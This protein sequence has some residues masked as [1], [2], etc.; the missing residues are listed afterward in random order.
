MNRIE[1]ELFERVESMGKSAFFERGISLMEDLEEH[2]GSF[3]LF[4]LM[5]LCVVTLRNLI[6]S[7]TSS[8]YIEQFG[9]YTLHYPLAFV[10][11]FL[12]LSILL[13]L[14]SGEPISRVSKLMFFLWFLIL[15]PP[16]VDLIRI[17][18][19][20]GTREV[21]GW[22]NFE[23]DGFW[24]TYINL[25]NPSVELEGATTGIRIQS[26]LSCILATVY[27]VIKSK[28]FVR[29]VITPIVISFFS[30]CFFSLPAL[31]VAVS[32]MITPE[33]V[34][35][36][37]MVLYEGNLIWNFSQQAA[38]GMAIYQLILAVILF[39][40]WLHFNDPEKLKLLL[41][42]ID[43]RDMIRMISFAALGFIIGWGMYLRE[44]D[45]SSLIGNHRDL[46]GIFAVS[47]T[48]VSVAFFRSAL[49]GRSTRKH[50]Y[51]PRDI[52]IVSL[53]F[54]LAFAAAASYPVLM[55]I[56]VLLILET[57]SYVSPFNVAAI[58]VVKQLVL[59]TNT[60]V[61]CLIGFT[62]FTGNLA[63]TLFPTIITITVLVVI[64]LA[65]LGRQP[66]D[67]TMSLTKRFLWFGPFTL[68]IIAAG[69]LIPGAKA[70]VG[71]SAIA[72]VFFVNAIILKS[73]QNGFGVTSL[74]AFVFGVHCLW[75]TLPSL[76]GKVRHFPAEL[77]HSIYATFLEHD[78]HA[79][80]AALEFQKAYD[81][82]SE[83]PW[84]AFQLG[85]YAL[86][87][88][89]REQALTYY[90][91]ALEL[92]PY[93]SK[94]L[95]NAAILLTG[96]DR[97]EESLL[98]WKRLLTEGR[99]NEPYLA[100]VTTFFIDQGRADESLEMLLT[101]EN[102]IGIDAVKRE[103]LRLLNSITQETDTTQ[104]SHL[105]DE[106]RAA[107]EDVFGQLRAGLCLWKMGRYNDAL[108]RFD[109]VTETIPSLTALYYMYGIMYL[110][111][112]ENSLAVH[113]YARFL[114][115]YPLNLEAGVN[116]GT[117]YLNLGE[118]GDAFVVLEA[119]EEKYPGDPRVMVNLANTHIRN[120]DLETAENILRSLVSTGSRSPLLHYNIG[121]LL[122]N[123]GKAREA[124][125]HFE[126][127]IREGFSNP[128]LLTRVGAYY[129]QA[130]NK[131]KA[132]QMYIQAIQLDSS[133]MPALTKLKR[134]R[135]GK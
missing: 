45:L 108:P 85:Y 67:V 133:F 110:K 97:N 113:A 1:P 135:K 35:A 41:L 31:F 127:A 24:P 21:V 60:L 55:W 32:S 73:R 120:G 40:L 119:L 5:F 89:N 48:L 6:E 2:E 37:S 105:L 58:P 93:Y 86:G 7:F 106:V 38:T 66:T 36:Q 101:T 125:S 4:L 103:S 53:V 117:A 92:D 99:E 3:R 15:L 74:L 39:F 22:L 71:M 77:K 9:T 44:I 30:F 51:D 112:G 122:E 42:T 81:L 128:T 63:P 131:E 20:E 75:S 17:V 54:S 132:E 13:A 118:L 115:D 16:V 96:M 72:A 100:N 98:Y 19:G 26:F 84:V 34:D 70:L 91:R 61:C 14:C 94:A 12:L 65:Y 88:E 46:T 87:D 126:N 95:N 33:V 49:L 59:S 27:V 121:V 79:E 116:I 107:P 56:L 29:A 11:A 83:D 102:D 25:Y 82:G 123:Q 23:A 130:G 124:V 76:V 78:G 104:L 129:E 47:L 18:A 134:L 52:M 69:L 68:S 114:E 10:I 109:R 80:L 28:N 57:V 90:E 111:M 50:P 64:F 43:I 8:G 62:L